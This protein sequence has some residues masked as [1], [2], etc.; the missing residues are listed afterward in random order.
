[1]KGKLKRVIEKETQKEEI[2]PDEDIS[3]TLPKI[4]TISDD[5]IFGKE[6]EK[7]REEEEQIKSEIDLQKLEDELDAGEVPKKLEFYFGG[8]NK[9]IF[10]ACQ[11]L[12]VNEENTFFIDFESLEI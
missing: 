12:G 4:S 9:K 1:M 11:K 2:V 6:Q 5:W 8:L 10:H 7:K 3:F